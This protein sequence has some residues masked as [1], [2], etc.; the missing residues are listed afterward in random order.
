M[1]RNLA[2]FKKGVIP[3]KERSSLAKGWSKDGDLDSLDA[4]ILAIETESL[5][6][7]YKKMNVPVLG[8]LEANQ[9]AEVYCW[10]YCQLNSASTEEPRDENTHEINWLIGTACRVRS[11]ASTAQTLSTCA[12]QVNGPRGSMVIG[13]SK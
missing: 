2:Q 4:T 12:H 5:G 13:Q 10:M 9:P 11:C 1:E 7:R 8:H 6:R 3:H